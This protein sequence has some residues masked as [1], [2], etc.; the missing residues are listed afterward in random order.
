MADSLIREAGGG[1]TPLL[2]GI[3]GIP[4]VARD[5]GDDLTREEGEEKEPPMLF[6]NDG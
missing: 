4:P 6:Q 5:I 1:D 3:L 2:L